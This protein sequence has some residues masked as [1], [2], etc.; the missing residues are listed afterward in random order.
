MSVVF[1]LLISELTQQAPLLSF[2]LLLT[3]FKILKSCLVDS[4]LKTV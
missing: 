1:L 2:V 3:I 4:F